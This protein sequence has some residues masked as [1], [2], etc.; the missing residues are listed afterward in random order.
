M[1]RLQAMSERAILIR[2]FGGEVLLSEPAPGAAAAKQVPMFF[3]RASVPVS[4]APLLVCTRRFAREASTLHAAIGTDGNKE[5]CPFL[6]TKPAVRPATC[7][8]RS[9]GPH[10]STSDP[11]PPPRG[12]PS[13]RL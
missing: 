8:R 13:C 6:A 4:A 11:F 1:P 3:L 7:S 12:F 9:A 2:A 10:V 5:S